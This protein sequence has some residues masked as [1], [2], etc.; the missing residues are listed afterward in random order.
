[1]KFLSVL[2]V[3][4][5]LSIAS[6]NA[7]PVTPLD[8]GSWFQFARIADDGQGMHDGN[9]Q[10]DSTYSFGT[11]TSGS[12]STDFYRP[13]NVYAGMEI[14]FITGD[15]TVW[16]K[17]DYGVLKALIDAFGGSQVANIAFDTKNGATTGNVLSRASAIEDPWISM[18]GSH[19]NGINNQGIIWGEN[20]WGSGS[21]GHTA[22]KNLSGGIDV[23]VSTATVPLPAGFVLLLSAGAGLGAMRMRKKA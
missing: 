13:F 5:G 23:F 11:F 15:R 16:A 2:A 10:L 8:S 4:L 19:S 18:S 12:Q 22:L 3:I 20:D 1:M 7:S 6:A 17:T 14:L 21:N 9:S